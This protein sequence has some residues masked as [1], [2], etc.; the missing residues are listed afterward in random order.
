MKPSPPKKEK[1]SA[2][3]QAPVIFKTSDFFGESTTA[4]QAKDGTEDSAQETQTLSSD[5]PT[6][7]S[8]TQPTDRW[9]FNTSN[10][11]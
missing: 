7:E 4:E 6:E 2:E 1:H 10:R 3:W 5:E 9:T 11:T 8:G